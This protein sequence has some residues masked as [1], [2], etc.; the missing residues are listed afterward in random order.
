[1]K[2]GHLLV[3]IGKIL[4]GGLVFYLGIILGSLVSDILGLPSPTMPAEVDQSKLT[5][6]F[7]LTSFILAGTLAFISVRLAG[8]FLSR[9]LILAFLT[10]ITYGVNTY[11][12]AAI[13][14]TMSSSALV[15]MYLVS[16]VLCAA[17]VAVLFRRLEPSQGFWS[18][19]KSFFDG[20]AVSE[21]IWR[22]VLAWLAFP[23]AYLIFGWLVMPFTYKFYQQ[24]LMG[25]KA[26]G[27]GEILPTLALRSLLFLLAVLPMLIFWAK[28]RASLFV[29]LGVTL[30]LLV[31][32]LALFQATW[33]TP[34]IR[35][36]HSLEI[37][38]DSFAHSGAVVLLL[39][40]KERIFPV[41][42]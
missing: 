41:L 36:A 4:L 20:R 12:E 27:W 16:S 3:T 7:L 31:G 33:Y 26:P 34:T 14:T 23:A 29:T 22:L 10:W 5:Y 42:N 32:G 15:V 17:V 30:F 19:T 37:L 18:R 21:W 13:F 2:I 11:L 39:V 1:V 38:A 28:S 35:I 6:Y 9:W 40:K 8:S 24:E 25:L